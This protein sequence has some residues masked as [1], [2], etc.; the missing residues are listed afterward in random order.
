MATTEQLVRCPHCGAN[1]RVSRDRVSHGD[2]PV[3]GRCRSPLPALPSGGPVVVTDAT[4]TTLVA[5]ST[6]PVLLDLWA[7]WCGPCRTLTPTLEILA[8][9]YG[10]RLR[11]AKLNVDENPATAARFEARSIPLLVI[12][13]GGQEVDRLVGL[14]PAN[15]IRQRLSRFIS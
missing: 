3:C 6:V 5:G 11:V 8:N 9:E 15:V 12:L 13:Q 10:G 7:P 2:A 14:H 1:N 4:F